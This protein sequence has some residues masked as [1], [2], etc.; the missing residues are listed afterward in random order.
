MGVVSTWTD[1]VL[2]TEL[3]PELHPNCARKGIFKKRSQDFKVTL[4]P[5]LPK[6]ECDDLSW[7]NPYLPERTLLFERAGLR[8]EPHP[9]STLRTK[10][11][12]TCSQMKP[13]ISISCKGM[14]C[15]VVSY[16]T[17]LAKINRTCFDL[18]QYSAIKI[19]Y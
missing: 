15:R 5:A 6:L 4:V 17:L 10:N 3:L 11:N 2:C 19:T 8:F 7:H 12:E 9:Q 14:H 16:I 18:L 1:P 13:Q